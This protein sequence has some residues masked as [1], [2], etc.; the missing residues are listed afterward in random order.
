MDVEYFRSNAAANPP[1][2]LQ[3][4]KL[5][6]DLIR[7]H[8][9]LL[10]FLV[11]QL[12]YRRDEE[13]AHLLSCF[14]RHLPHLHLLLSPQQLG[15]LVKRVHPVRQIHFS[16]HQDCLGPWGLVVA[17]QLQPSPHITQTL[18]T[19]G[20]I[21]EKGHICVSEVGRHQ[22]FILFLACG[23]PQLQS[24]G[25]VMDGQVAREEVYADSGLNSCRVTLEAES[26]SSLTKRSMM[27]VLP[28]PVSPSST[29]LNLV[30]QRLVLSS[31]LMPPLLV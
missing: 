26:N 13:L 5:G 23:V 12:R 7:L 30:S 15:F 22:T 16:A 3:R 17:E 8:L 25:A 1:L 9:V 27:E 14:G 2:P 31:A 21:Y 20:L 6:H 28:T 29:S 4:R 18:C 11:R 19:G 24:K 10:H